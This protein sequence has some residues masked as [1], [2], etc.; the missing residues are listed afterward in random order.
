MFGKRFD[1]FTL[2]GFRVRIDTSWLLLAVLV[3]WSLATGVFPR[4]HGELSPV[5]YWLMGAAAAL[6]LF[7][8]FVVHEFAHSMVARR[9]GVV[10]RGIT[11]FIFG[12]V[13]EMADET[14]SA[15]AEFRVA[16]AGPIASALIAAV[17]LAAARLGDALGWPVPL[18][19]VIFYVGMINGALVVFNLIPAFPLDGG[20]I[21][22][23]ALWSWRKDLAWATFV[24]SRIGVGFSYVLMAVGVWSVISG[25]YI[26]GIWYFLIGLFLRGAA[27]TSYRQVVFRRSLEGETVRRFMR[28]DPVTVPA[29]LSIEK[30]VQ[31][32]VYHY[33]FKMFPVVEAG[34]LLGCVRT[35]EIRDVPRE[36]WASRSVRELTIPVCDENSIS[37]EAAATEALA[38]MNRSETSRLLVVENGDLVGVITLKDLLKYLSLKIE[39][40]PR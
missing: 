34:N 37:P 16:V 17:F 7:L 40:E 18:L 32:H 9:H 2:L 30:L 11:L 8:S 3:T 33:H 4:W 26:G 25:N 29:D 15:R 35:R 13:A 22:R 28:A 20:R 6:G 5:T 38:K 27:N 10:M 31:D 12:G 14:P 36:E 1:L 19:G 39:L 23:S 21:L 24:S